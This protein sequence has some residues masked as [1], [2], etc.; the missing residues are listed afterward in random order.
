MQ[1]AHKKLDAMWAKAREFTG[2]EVTVT[3]KDGR[4][5]KGTITDSYHD[6]LVLKQENGQEKYI[7]YFTAVRIRAK[8]PRATRR[9]SEERVKPKRKKKPIV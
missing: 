2:A 3:T 5:L 6:Y 8:H 9:P 7:D 4:K 1:Q